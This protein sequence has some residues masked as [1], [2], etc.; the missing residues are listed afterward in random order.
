MSKGAGHR[1][2]GLVRQHE[3]HVIVQVAPRLGRAAGQPEIDAVIDRLVAA[4]EAL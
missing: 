4:I 1:V 3:V 2:P